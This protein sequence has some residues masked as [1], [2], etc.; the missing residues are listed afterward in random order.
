MVD[1]QENNKLSYVMVT[2]IVINADL[3]EL[4]ISLCL[5]A[6]YSIVDGKKERKKERRTN[7]I[8]LYAF[9]HSYINIYIQSRVFNVDIYSSFTVIVVAS[10]RAC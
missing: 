1:E 7:G 2:T 6:V 10:T 4:E 5:C 8:Y 9:M 3:T